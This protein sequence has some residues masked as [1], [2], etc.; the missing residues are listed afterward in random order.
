VKARA[1]IITY[2]LALTSSLGACA[3]GMG[4]SI[5]DA[6]ASA[7]NIHVKSPV[8]VYL[9]MRNVEGRLVAPPTLRNW[10][11]S[12]SCDMYNEYEERSVLVRKHVCRTRLFEGGSVDFSLRYGNDYAEVVGL[13][14]WIR[15]PAEAFL[16]GARMA[17]ASM[18]VDQGAALAE[19]PFLAE[20]LD[21]GHLTNVSKE[22]WIYVAESSAAYAVYVPVWQMVRSECSLYLRQELLILKGSNL[23]C[24]VGSVPAVI[25]GVDCPDS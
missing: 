2:F 17:H 14:R 8:V 16:V 18:S 7:R 10:L 4:G 3:H 22:A 20:G 1:M 24:S 5:S 15:S 6:C 19:F 23:V 25:L 9:D 11:E 21:L 13:K 12:T